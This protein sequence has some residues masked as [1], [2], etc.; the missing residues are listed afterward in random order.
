MSSSE[1]AFLLALLSVHLWTS[2]GAPGL[3]L[4]NRRYKNRIQDNMQS[5][6]PVLRKFTMSKILILGF[7]IDIIIH[8]SHTW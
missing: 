3:L 4:K 5:I 1:T 6:N 2:S 8:K 7:F